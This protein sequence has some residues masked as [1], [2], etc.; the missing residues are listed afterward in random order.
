[1]SL[2]DFFFNAD[3]RE[4]LQCNCNKKETIDNYP[5][6]TK[7][8][9]EQDKK[10]FWEQYHLKSMQHKVDLLSSEIIYGFI[11]K[12]KITFDLFKKFLISSGAKEYTHN[13]LWNEF[14]EKHK[15]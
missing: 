14:K 6:K 5:K 12:N 15:I 2:V 13:V 10:E 9:I 4:S 11:D 7:E 3:Y 1:M 8:E